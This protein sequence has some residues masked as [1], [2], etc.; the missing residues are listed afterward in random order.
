MSIKQVS[1][2]HYDGWTFSSSSLAICGGRTQGGRVHRYRHLDIILSFRNHF[3]CLGDTLT[4]L[5]TFIDWSKFFGRYLKVQPPNHSFDFKKTN[6][7][8][9]LTFSSIPIELNA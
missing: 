3:S 8:G 4:L 2:I 9:S 6:N 7:C 5:P 1:E